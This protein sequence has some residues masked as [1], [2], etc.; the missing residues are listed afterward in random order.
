MSRAHRWSGMLLGAAALA[1]LV[2]CAQD[3]GSIDGGARPGG[4]VDI[5]PNPASQ[6]PAASAGSLAAPA[7]RVLVD[8]RQPVTDPVGVPEVEQSRV[9][10]L[11]F[12]QGV[13]AGAV[14]ADHREGRFTADAPQ[15]AWLVLPRGA[16][17]AQPGATP[18]LL[19]VTRGDT[20]HA[21]LPMEVPYLTI[22]AIA[23]IDGDGLDDLL[24]RT[25]GT[26]MGEAFA[27]L[28]AVS[29]AGG[30]ARRVDRFASA[31]S[32]PCGVVAGAEAGAAV[33]EIVDG[34]LQRRDFRAPCPADGAPAAAD[35]TP[36]PQAPG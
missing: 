30:A 14:V 16:R 25:D 4:A 32:I 36:A 31:L 22:P 15:Q 10:A 3:A 28:D 9:L 34:R 35:Y 21:R 26:Q 6:P 18:A 1:G 8:F 29:L 13:P 23:D 17:A 7:R 20:V 5:D 33:I 12:P 2:A 27:A 19:L 24:L 11:A